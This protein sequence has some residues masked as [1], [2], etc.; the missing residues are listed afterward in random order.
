MTDFR[1]ALVR[2][3]LFFPP[4]ELIVANGFCGLDNEIGEHI[5]N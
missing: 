2:C 5:F 4:Y 3:P 1:L